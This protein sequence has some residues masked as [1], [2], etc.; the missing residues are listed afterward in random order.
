MRLETR[1]AIITGGGRGIG[2]AIALAFAREGAD[3]V[4]VS[5]TMGEVEET[6]AAARALGR[7]ALALRVDVSCR[8]DVEAMV[9]TSLQQFGK[10]DILVNNAGIY[11]PIGPLAENDPDRW[12]ETIKVNLIGIFLCGRAV[13]PAMMRQSHGKIINLSGGGASAP[14]PRFSAYAASKAAVVRLTETLAQEVKGYNIQVNAIAPGPVAT[15]LT[16]DVL[17]AGAAAGEDM[18]R[19]ARRVKDGGGTPADT[20]AGL[21]VFLASTE[22]NG[23]TGRVISAVWDQ[24]RQFPARMAEIMDSDLYTLRRVVEGDRA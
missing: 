7:R 19:Q 20:A 17:A 18:V 14:L 6:A 16:D 22:S 4:V 10:V 24:W 1:V 5:R 11:G 8:E 3:L 9:R 23:L 21:A 15:R 13:L 2:K 12:L